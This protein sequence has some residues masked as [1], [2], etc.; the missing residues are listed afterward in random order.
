[1]QV[2]VT[3]ELEAGRHIWLKCL[4]RSM[5]ISQAENLLDSYD[6]LAEEEARTKAGVVVNLVSDLNSEIFE[7]IVS[8]GG[9]M[10]EALKNWF[11]RNWGN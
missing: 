1:M 11:C 6:R 8:G 9:H 3:K 4:T 5:D 10:S 7:Q 2:V